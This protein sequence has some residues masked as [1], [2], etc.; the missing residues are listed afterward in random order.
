MSEKKKEELSDYRRTID[1]LD[2]HIIDSLAQR[3]RIVREVFS[4]KITDTAR[5]RDHEREEQ[6]LKRVREMAVESGLDPYFA[7]QLFRDI[8]YQSVRYQSHSLLD[9]QNDM[10]EERSITVAYQG[11]D[12]AFSH[13]AAMRHFHE[14]YDDIRCTGFRTFEQAATAV[15]E[16]HANVAILPIENTTAGSIN[17]TYDLLGEKKLHII[18]EEVLRVVHC[19]MAPEQVQLENIRRVLSHPQ[20]IA[21]C[22]RFLAKLP[23]CK[24]ESYDDTAMAAQKVRDEADLSQAAIASAYAAEIYGLEILVKDIANQSENFTR[25]VVVSRNPVECDLQLPC[26]TSLMLATVHEKGALFKCLQVLN[27]HGISMT[28]L[29]SRPRHGKPWQ[30][31]FYMDIEGNIKDPAVKRAIKELEAR[32]AYMKVLGC[33]AV[34][35]QD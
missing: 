2:K 19:L 20:A 10:F 33:Y 5:I 13:Q 25:F 29:E 15:E 31:L 3:H 34:Q 8:I 35:S 16:G 23:R 27:K 32:A 17:D 24:I 22:S 11:T 28:K 9:H 12:G 1:E 14:R 21:Q 18:G 4:A 6:L 30:Y 26:K 7:E